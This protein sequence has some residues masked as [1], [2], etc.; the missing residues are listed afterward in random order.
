M[1]VQLVDDELLKLNSTENTMRQNTAQMRVL[2]RALE[3]S[4]GE[5]ALAKAL[6]VSGEALSGWLAGGMI[7]PDVYFKTLALVAKKRAR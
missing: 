3:N 2:C 6:G 7:P 1:I 4:D 5:P